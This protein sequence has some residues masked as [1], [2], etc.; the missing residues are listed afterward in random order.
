MAKFIT[1]KALED[2]IYNIIW[3]AERVL[4]IVSPFIK[5]DDYFKKLFDKHVN[6]TKI[7]LIIVFG[8]NE[9]AVSRSLSKQ[10]FDYF[11][12]FLNI[13]IV[14]VPNLH[15]KYYG[16][17]QMGVITSINLYDYSFINNIEFGVYSEVSIFDN[18]KT[19]TDQEAWKTCKDIAESNEAVFIKRPVYEKK[20]LSAFLGNSYVK[21]DIL[22]DTTDKFYSGFRSNK[23]NNVV[24]KLIDFEEELILGSTP[25]PR[26]TREEVE[27][28]PKDVS[29]SYSENRRNGYCIRTGV[30]II[31]NI[32]KPFSYE[33]YLEW[34]KFENP[35]YPEK[36][37]HYSG[38]RSKGETS[39]NK[40]ILGKYWD[41]ANEVF[42]LKKKIF[43]K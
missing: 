43:K 29:N 1:G 17:E 18:L 36:Y 21:S 40:P 7:H 5:L 8:K 2:A 31:F 30:E 6:N 20:L 4:M 13:S 10:D 28:K 26:P 35:D 38:E 14:Y 41:E 19:S 32:E 34:N 15:A 33:A 22:H 27:S 11:K 3:D 9:G 12:K 42:K 25:T 16:N 24:K 39:F 23:S 37:C